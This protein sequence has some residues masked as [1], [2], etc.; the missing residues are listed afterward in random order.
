MKRQHPPLQLSPTRGERACAFRLLKDPRIGFAVRDDARPLP[1]KPARP[2]RIAGLDLAGLQPGGEPA[3]ALLRRT[4]GEA[5]GHYAALALLLQSV[6]ADGRRSLDRFLDVARLERLPALVGV[7]RPD[8]R[9]AIRQ[10]LD[11]DGELV[12]LRLSDLTLA[13]LDAGQD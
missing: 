5:V 10:Q 7:V 2:E 8:A 11:A 4:M 1:L 3:R 9:E 6:V 13:L 12:G